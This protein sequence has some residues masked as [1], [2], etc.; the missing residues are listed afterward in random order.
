M[1][2]SGISG[3]I[4]QKDEPNQQPGRFPALGKR[5]GGAY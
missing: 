5:A 3:E 2:M 4:A 1:I